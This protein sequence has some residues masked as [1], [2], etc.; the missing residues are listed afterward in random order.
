LI[1]DETAVSELPDTQ[2]NHYDVAGDDAWSIR[3]SMN[4]LRPT[5]AHDG[6]P[7]DAVTNW[8]FDWIWPGDG[9]GGCDLSRVSV[10]FRATVLLPRLMRQGLDAK[11]AKTWTRYIAALSLHEAGHVRHAYEHRED[12]ANAIRASTCATANAAGQAAIATLIQY[13]IDYD[14]ATHHGR[15]Q[16]VAFP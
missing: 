12:V 5:D 2:V 11:L 13:D 8:R 14:G 7:M 4:A 3:S 16:G 1:V 6:L 15:T 10:G 9:K